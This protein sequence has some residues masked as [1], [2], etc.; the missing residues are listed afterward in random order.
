MKGMRPLKKG[1]GTK[2]LRSGRPVE[3]K[4]AMVL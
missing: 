4:G 1:S 2:G 3:G